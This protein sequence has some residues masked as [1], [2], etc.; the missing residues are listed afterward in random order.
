MAYADVVKMMLI[1]SIDELAKNPE[2][3]A[4]HP[5]KDFT[6]NRKLCFKDFILLL[7]TMEGD[8]IREELYRFFGRSEETPKKA[9]YC[10]QRAKLKSDSLLNLLHIFTQ[11][12]S[13][14]LYKDKYSLV[15]YWA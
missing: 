3:F 12:F 8:C 13:R 4:V 10:N 2:Q 5:G 11:K 9:A 6:R 7:L 15:A 1:A 14:N